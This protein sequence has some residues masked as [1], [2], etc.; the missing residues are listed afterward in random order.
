MDTTDEVHGSSQPAILEGGRLSIWQKLKSSDLKRLFLVCIGV[1]A[2]MG[3]FA[4]TAAVSI[5]WVTSRPIPVREWPRLEMKGV[6]LKAK[7]KTDWNDTVRYQLLVTPLSDD[8]KGAFDT[9]V[10]A[11]RS[12]ISF[13]VHLYDKSGFE[14]C[15]QDVKPAPFVN[16][17]GHYDELGANSI[18]YSPDCPRARYKDADRWSLSYIFP[19]ITADSPV[20]RQAVVPGRSD[21]KP[22][23]STGQE[24]PSEGDDMLTGFD[25]LSGHLE[26]RSGKTFLINREGER[27]AALMWGTSSAIHFDCKSTD[28]CLIENT[29]NKA[30]VH[31]R[32]L[33]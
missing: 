9:T 29:G 24:S 14:V 30:A 17:E 3:I 6:G 28:D 11:D 4:L 32:L 8:L 19:S 18:F 16:A 23:R 13:T 31:G 1:G 7:L 33:R 12:T 21:A 26:T 22:T 2:G 15:T 10:R 20:P 27:Y 25:L 5:N